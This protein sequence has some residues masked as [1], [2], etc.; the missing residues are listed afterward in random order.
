MNHLP[1]SHGFR[2]SYGVSGLERSHKHHGA[3]GHPVQRFLGGGNMLQPQRPTT[4]D[5]P[6][7]TVKMRG[8]YLEISQNLNIHSIWIDLSLYKYKKYMDTYGSLNYIG[9]GKS[10]P[11]FGIFFQWVL[12]QPTSPFITIIAMSVQMNCLPQCPSDCDCSACII[13]IILIVYLQDYKSFLTWFLA[14]YGAV[15]QHNETKSSK[16]APTGCKLV[17]S[18]ITPSH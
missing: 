1:T 14:W 15:K 11:K 2:R 17:Y 7:M 8:N 9:L 12:T 10:S 18:F 3:A 16:G 6:D 13:V 5:I 4:I